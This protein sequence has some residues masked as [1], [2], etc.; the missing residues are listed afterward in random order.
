[1]AGQARLWNRMGY[2]QICDG[3]V[4]IVSQ[5]VFGVLF[6]QIPLIRKNSVRIRIVDRVKN[7]N[8]K[9][10]VPCRDRGT[11]DP[12]TLVVKREHHCCFYLLRLCFS[13]G[14]AKNRV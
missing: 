2:I 3:Y 6:T 8:G 1:M 10:D 5:N 4:Q 9:G 14:P 13:Q 12:L 7:A 11:L